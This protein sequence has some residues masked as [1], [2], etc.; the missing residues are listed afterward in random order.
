MFCES[1][2]WHLVWL[3]ASRARCFEFKATRYACQGCINTPFPFV[4]KVFGSGAVSAATFGVFARLDGA[5]LGLGFTAK[6]RGCC[7]AAGGLCC[8]KEPSPLPQV[9]DNYRPS[10]KQTIKQR[11]RRHAFGFGIPDFRA[12]AARLDGAGSGVFRL[13]GVGVLG[14]AV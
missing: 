11:L 12:Q 14:L 8:S 2:V 3:E 4:W 9:E 6:L 13:A 5:S 10:S 7:S 1:E